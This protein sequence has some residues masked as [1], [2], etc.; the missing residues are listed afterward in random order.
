MEALLKN[1]SSMS[2]VRAAAVK[3]PPLKGAVADSLSRPVARG[4]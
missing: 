3:C 2:D 1:C 4:G